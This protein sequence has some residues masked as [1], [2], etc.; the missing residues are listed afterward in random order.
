MKRTQRYIVL[1]A[2]FAALTPAIGLSAQSELDV[3]QAEGFIGSW[4]VALETQMGAMSLDLEIQDV[5]GKVG[6]TLGSPEL[7]GNQAIEDI[8]RSGEALVLRYAM[9]AQG[10]M[11]PVSVNLAPSGDDLTAQFDFA[12]GQFVASGTATRADG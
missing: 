2:L 6:A 8:T 4:D 9:D 11:V 3:A 12:G 1:F 7:G 5:D 10:Q